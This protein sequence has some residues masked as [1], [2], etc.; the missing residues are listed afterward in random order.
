MEYICKVLELKDGRSVRFEFS[1]SSEMFSEKQINDI[2]EVVKEYLLHF[3]QLS[4]CIVTDYEN[5]RYQNVD[6]DDKYD[7]Q[8]FYDDKAI[9]LNQIKF[10]S[11]QFED[12]IWL[13]DIEK[14]SKKILNLSIK[15]QELP[16]TMSQEDADTYIAAIM[17]Q[18]NWKKRN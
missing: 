2:I 17:S 7:G 9:V 3:P 6:K 16:K 12:K 10:A 15:I 14:Y 8:A 4:I 1:E 11:K 13:S 18:I 5:E